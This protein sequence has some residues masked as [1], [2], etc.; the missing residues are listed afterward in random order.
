[1]HT[2]AEY[3]VKYERKQIEEILG[4]YSNAFWNGYMAIWEYIVIVKIEEFV[5]EVVF[6]NTSERVV[7]HFFCEP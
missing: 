1:M 4:T 2:S 5:Y 7:T 3:S 6:K